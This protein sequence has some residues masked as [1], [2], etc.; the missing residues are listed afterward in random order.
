LLL[1]FFPDR[2]VVI[3]NS[4][5]S[6]CE[7]LKRFDE[8][9]GCYKEAIRLEPDN[10]SNY[11][12]LGYLYKIQHNIDAALENY[13]KGLEF[14]KDLDKSSVVDVNNRLEALKN[15]HN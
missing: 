4:L 8:A 13:E 10:G 3:V 2:R 14:G 15:A 7:R 9:E 12:D 5:G 6:F 11:I 1:R